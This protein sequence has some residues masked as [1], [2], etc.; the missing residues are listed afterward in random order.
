M[1]GD[2]VPDELL[3][4]GVQFADGRSVTNLDPAPSHPEVPAFK[5]PMLSSGPGTGGGVGG[6]SFDMVY[7]VRPLPLP[8]P[9]AFVCV[10]P[11]RGI[12]PS[13]VEV[14]GAAAVRLWADDPYC[15]AD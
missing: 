1:G 4:F 2:L 13:R 6:W 9:L 12:P 15:S 8:G 7:R 5:Q 3:R 14:D 11:E 10:W